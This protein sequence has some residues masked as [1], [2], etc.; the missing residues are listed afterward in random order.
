MK[1]EGM[2]NIDTLDALVNSCEPSKR[3]IV[4]AVSQATVEALTIVMKKENLEPEDIVT[5][6]NCISLAVEDIFIN[7]PAQHKKSPL[8]IAK[9]MKL[10]GQIA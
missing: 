9:L 4:M 3:P 10:A 1:I 2:N 8:F 6:T 5:I 7:M